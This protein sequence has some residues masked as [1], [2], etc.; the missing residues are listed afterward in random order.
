MKVGDLIYDDYYGV[1]V[2]LEIEHGEGC[3]HFC[4]EDKKCWL[5]EE[6]FASVEVISE[7]R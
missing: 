3:I 5:D 2:I 6:L 4:E 1:G 7:S